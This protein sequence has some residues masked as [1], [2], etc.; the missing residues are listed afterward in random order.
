MKNKILDTFGSQNFL[1]SIFT[2]IFAAFAANG[3]P[4]DLDPG[5]AAQTIGEGNITAIATMF[6]VNLLNPVF[7][8]INK[9][10]TWSWDFIRSVNFWT[11]SLTVI[12]V[13]VAGLGIVFPEGA[14]ENVVD[15]IFGGNFG[16]IAT[17]LVVNILNPLY[18]FFFDR[19]KDPGEPQPA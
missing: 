4:I 14:A 11:Q 3:L 15:A 5:E 2:I 16:V 9:S 6:V 17:A 19:K 8:L 13:A 1:V 12:L 10:A 7:K 18:H